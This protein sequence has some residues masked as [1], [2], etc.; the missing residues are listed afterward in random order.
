MYLVVYFQ[1]DNLS[2]Y[3]DILF[4]FT[5]CSVLS[6]FGH[7]TCFFYALLVTQTRQLHI[8]FFLKENPYI[9]SLSKRK[10]HIFRLIKTVSLSLVI[11]IF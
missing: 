7:F 8:Y 10:L 4:F 2:L 9:F 1:V 6:F 5:L 3:K 11:I